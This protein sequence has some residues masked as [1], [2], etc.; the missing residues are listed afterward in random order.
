MRGNDT[1]TWASPQIAK[2]VEENKEYGLG[3]HTQA[4]MEQVFAA[5]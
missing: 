3:L 1:S 2:L 5:L 4:E